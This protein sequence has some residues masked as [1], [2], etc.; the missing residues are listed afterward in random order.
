M[1][2]LYGSVACLFHL[3]DRFRLPG[4]AFRGKNF[5]RLSGRLAHLL[6]FGPRQC[7]PIRQKPLKLS[8]AFILP[9]V[10][11]FPEDAFQA[12]TLS[13]QKREAAGKGLPVSS[14]RCGPSPAI[15]SAVCFS[16]ACFW[17]RRSSSMCFSF[18]SLP[19]Y[20]RSVVPEET[21]NSARI[22]SRQA[23]SLSPAYSDS[24]IPEGTT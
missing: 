6:F 11:S 5:R 19:T 24:S 22:L 12:V 3:I 18:A 23:A 16:R 4:K 20:R 14:L 8:G 2:F 7:H 17:K 13:A 21:E 10:L 1:P 9:A 15:S